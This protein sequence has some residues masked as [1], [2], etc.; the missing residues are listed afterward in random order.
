M[1]AGVARRAVGLGGA[2]ARCGSIPGPEGLQPGLGQLDLVDVV[3][4]VLD[5]RKLADALAARPGSR[6]MVGGM[7]D[8]NPPPHPHHDTALDAP[9]FGRGTAAVLGGLIGG[10]WT[11]LL[12]FFSIKPIEQRLPQW[13][14]IVAG[15]LTFRYSMRWS[16]DWFE[17]A[18]M[19]WPIAFAT[20]FLLG[21][22]CC[23][24][25]AHGACSLTVWLLNRRGGRSPHSP[26]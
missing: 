22:M 23:L 21:V 9:R 13:S 19:S 3:A 11:G 2:M 6:C 14:F 5:P 25:A 18:G 10:V 26:R 20:A 1:A 4:G 15:I 7:I 12:R 16:L 8:Q 17:S 24:A